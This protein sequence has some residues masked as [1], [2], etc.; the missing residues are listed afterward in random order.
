MLEAI[1][2][3]KDKGFIFDVELYLDDDFR[4]NH[5]KVIEKYSNIISFNRYVKP[6]KYI[7]LLNSAD[8]LI[9]LDVDE[10]F[11]KLFF[12]SKLVDYIG[13]ENQI[14]HIGKSNTF[15]KHLIL[16]N[17]CLSSLND[18]ITL[19]EVLKKVIIS[20]KTFIPNKK[21]ID[22]YRLE[23]VSLNLANFLD[24]ITSNVKKNL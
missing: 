19:Q 23:K 14:L 7:E 20:K 21:L 11:G 9:L 17:N 22:K 2:N 16:K 4:K 12:Q 15:N 3:L 10:D 13:S 5:I 1:K 6:L 18:S 8:L 24:K